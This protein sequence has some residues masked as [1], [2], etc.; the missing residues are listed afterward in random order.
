MVMINAGILDMLARERQAEM[1]RKAACKALA[2]ASR[3][4]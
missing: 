3:R 4:R 1:E 2:A